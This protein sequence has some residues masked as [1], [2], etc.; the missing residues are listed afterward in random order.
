MHVK[1]GLIELKFEVNFID[2]V[3]NKNE[4]SLAEVSIH[5][6]ESLHINVGSINIKGKPLTW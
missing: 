6:K 3:V 4:I 5:R 2:A 1:T